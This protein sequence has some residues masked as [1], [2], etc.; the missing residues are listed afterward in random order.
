MA[1]IVKF[2]RG[3]GGGGG[4]VG[5]GD[6]Y[7]RTHGECHERHLWPGAIVCVDVVREIL[8]I[9]WIVESASGNGGVGRAVGLG[10][11][12]LRTIGKRHERHLWPGAVAC[13]DVVRETLGIAW[14]VKFASVEVLS[15]EVRQRYLA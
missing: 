12:C 5:L 1:C 6:T 7:F 13:V 4:A 14:R 10:D 2:V 3:N 8:G 15:S 11:I 9:A